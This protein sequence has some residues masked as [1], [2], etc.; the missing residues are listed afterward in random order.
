MKT[1]QNTFRDYCLVVTIIALLLKLLLLAEMPR[2]LTYYC[3]VVT[4]SDMRVFNFK[5]YRSG[6]FGIEIDMVDLEFWILEADG[7]RDKRI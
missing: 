5:D 4:I 3:F 2:L 6:G 7:K 1:N